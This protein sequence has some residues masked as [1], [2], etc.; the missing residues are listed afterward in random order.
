[1]K[2]SLFFLIFL[3]FLIVYS[4]DGILDTSFGNEG[5][6]LTTVN[7]EAR[8]TG[9]VIQSDGK[10]VITGFTYSE[11]YG[12]DVICLRYNINGEI[13]NSFGINGIVSYD[14][15]MGSDDKALSIDIQD[16]GKFIL[17]GYSDDGTNKAALLMR[18]NSDGSKDTSFGDEGIVMTDFTTN[19][20]PVRQDEYRVARIHHLTGNIIVG[21]TSYSASNNSRAIVARY[22]SEGNLDESFASGGKFTGLPN[23]QS[24][25]NF[26]FSIEDVALA[27]NGKITVVGWSSAYLYLGRLNS[28]GTMDTTFSSDGY[29]HQW[30]GRTYGVELNNDNSFYFTG[31]IWTAPETQLYTGHIE[32]NGGGITAT[33]FFFGS[34]MTA[35]SFAIERDLNG[36]LIVAGYLQ[37]DNSGNASFLVGR[38]LEDHSLDTTFG[39]NGFTVTTFQDP[40]S[41]AFDM[42]IQAD[43]KIVLAGMSGQKIA[44]A[45]YKTGQLSTE[46]TIGNLDAVQLF[47]NPAKDYIKI[48]FE[49]EGFENVNYQITDLNGRIVKVGNLSFGNNRV[50]I[51]NLN[52]GVYF[53]NIEGGKNKP[54]KFM[55]N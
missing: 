13:D 17:A 49:K 40:V 35:K 3:S 33:P 38:L 28:N 29:N 23:S 16:D 45:R 41:G 55:K 42:K 15:Q 11:T 53:V 4:Q 25:N 34:T 7:G 48:R 24:S 44:L 27:P 9:M 5:K 8:A 2:K 6:V 36:R 10:I 47:P 51:R 26:L 20:F 18:L 54:L 12:Y 43:G 14:I 37:N 1:M 52:K 22:T 39:A 19:D 30:G 21:G 46:E 31:D 32:A 50:D